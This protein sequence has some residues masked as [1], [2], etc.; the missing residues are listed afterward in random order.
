MDQN[1]QS[2][3]QKKIAL[4]QSEHASII[5]EILKD[6][7]TK[8]PLVADTEWK[9]IVSTL[10]LDAQSSLIREVVDY[11]ERIRRGELHDKQ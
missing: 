7:T 4:A 6:C 11:L 8:M 1:E 9:T 5:V 10:T 3:R 2:L